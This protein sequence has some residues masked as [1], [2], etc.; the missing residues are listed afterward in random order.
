M[1][2][3]DL[4]FLRLIFLSLPGLVSNVIPLLDKGICYVCKIIA[5]SPTMTEKVSPIM[6][7]CFI[8]ISPPLTTYLSIGYI[9]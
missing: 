3:A 8:T 6:T 7:Q 9:S 2:K 1:R 4:S 5:S